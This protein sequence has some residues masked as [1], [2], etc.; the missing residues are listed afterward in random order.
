MLCMSLLMCVAAAIFQ[1]KPSKAGRKEEKERKNR[2]ERRMAS[3]DELKK[4][5]DK[6][7]SIESVTFVEKQLK[8]RVEERCSATEAEDQVKELNKLRED[9]ASP[10]KP[11]SEAGT[12]PSSDEDD[13]EEEKD[14][15]E[16]EKKKEK[17]SSSDGESSS[18]GEEK[19]EEFKKTAEELQQEAVM[20]SRVE[21]LAEM[22]EDAESRRA[23]VA[24]AGKSVAEKA[25]ETKEEAAAGKA[26]ET[27]EEAIAGKAK[28]TDEE[29]AGKAKETDEEAAGKAKET[30]EEAEEA[31]DQEEPR[32]LKTEFD[33]YTQSLWPVITCDMTEDPRL[34]EKALPSQEL[35]RQFSML[36]EITLKPISSL[37]DGYGLRVRELKEK[38]EGSVI[39]AD[40][41]L[42]VL[43]DDMNKAAQNFN[44]KQ[45]EL[46][47]YV[48]L[49]EKELQEKVEKKQI[50]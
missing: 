1:I 18:S 13:K 43:K 36:R 50:R 32:R 33:I 6:T 30:D 28:E 47:D 41:S 19:K 29:T 2:R 12:D 31:K 25:E 14:E 15:K 37:P 23:K 7:R 44:D 22:K 8:K 48:K 27:N 17:E 9:K 45:A 34:V 39:D 16:K 4:I 35:E 20:K 11:V 38:V 24:E 49:L 5:M 46:K 42:S 26:E 21:D 40:E 10:E 3:D